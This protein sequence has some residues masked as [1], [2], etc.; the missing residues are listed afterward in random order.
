MKKYQL[1]LTVVELDGVRYISA[2][3]L[4]KLLLA[5]LSTEN[6]DTVIPA[7]LPDVPPPPP[8]PTKE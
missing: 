5:L 6:L 1:E 7:I 3:S 4:Q 8:P 2:A